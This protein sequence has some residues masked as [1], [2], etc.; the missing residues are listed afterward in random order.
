MMVLRV[1][2]VSHVDHSIFH[3]CRIGDW[4]ERSKREIGDRCSISSSSC[5]FLGWTTEPSRPI[6]KCPKY[7]LLAW[8]N[9]FVLLW[10][11]NIAL[12]QHPVVFLFA[13][14]LPLFLNR[15]GCPSGR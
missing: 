15:A 5:K 11:L 2:I 14:G 9:V 10:V 4:R 8:F 6:I 3:D 7:K 12:E 1:L 13:T